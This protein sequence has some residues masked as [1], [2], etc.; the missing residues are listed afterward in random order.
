MKIKRLGFTSFKISTDNID[1]ITDPL[2]AKNAGASIAKTTADVILLSDDNLSGKSDILES[3]G[4]SKFEPAHREKIF[5]ISSPGEYEVGG[6]L[7]RRYLDTDFYILDEG[8]VRI[9]YMGEISHKVEINDYSELGDV[10]LLITPVGDSE[11]FASYDKLEKIISKID[12]TYLIPSGY[13][14]KGLSDKFGDLKSI[15]DFIKYFGYTHIT[16]DKSFK[17]TSGTEPENKVIEIVVLE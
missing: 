11:I 3:N 6:I 7:I 13:K 12:P 15:D 8:H 2:L 5:E 16:H 1:I 4:L 9:V 10:D 17:I 14:E